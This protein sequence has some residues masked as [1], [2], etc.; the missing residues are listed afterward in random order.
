MIVRRRDL[1]HCQDCHVLRNAECS[2]DHQL[3]CLTL[4]LPQLSSRQR[5][6]R[7]RHH[8][9]TER[10]QLRPGASED[11]RAAAE[12]I[13]AEFCHH[14]STGLDGWDSLTSVEEKWSSLRSAI[15]DA[16]KKAIGNRIGF[17]IV[18]LSLSLC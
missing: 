4:V 10:L 12:C 14:I 1:L 5:S 16:A 3:L 11:E 9:F 2:T 6:T 13:R 7:V 15:T 18:M 8:F 17:E